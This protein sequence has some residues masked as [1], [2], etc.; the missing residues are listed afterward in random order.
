MRKTAPRGV[1]AVRPVS[2]AR[3]AQ[4]RYVDDSGPGIRRSRSGRGFSYTAD[5]GGA[6]REAS[7][8]ARIGSLAIPPAWTAVWICATANG[9]LQATGR[10]ARGRKQY[11]YH[12]RWRVA[13]DETKYERMLS[14]GR[15]LPRIRAA[16]ARDLALPGMPRERVLATVVRLLEA[17]LVR[18]GNEEYARTNHSFGLTTLTDRHVEVDGSRIRFHFRGKSGKPHDITMTDRRLARLVHRCRDLPGQHLFQYLDDHGEPQ[19]IESADVNQYLREISDHDFTAKDFRTWAGTLLAAQQLDSSDAAADQ[20]D[21]GERRATGIGSA[22]AAVAARLGNT[23]AVCRKSYIH[24]AVLQAFRDRA[25]YD[26]WVRA[27]LRRTC[28]DHLDA[29][30]TALLRFLAADRTA[31]D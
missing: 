7:T 13:R 8:L 18:V 14:F 22:I 4:L 1:A 21:A 3:A 20:D 23:V 12:P 6:V 24:P 5:D 16:V 15:A 11:R 26:R 30:E 19:P 9:H 29:D 2:D 28:R 31:G 17:T 10:D 27:C 25:L